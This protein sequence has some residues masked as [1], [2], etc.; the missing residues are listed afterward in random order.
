MRAFSL[1]F[2]INMYFV[3]GNC[4]PTS[5]QK[6]SVRDVQSQQGI[7]RNKSYSFELL[8][9]LELYS[10]ASMGTTSPDSYGLP[11]HTSPTLTPAHIKTPH[12]SCK[13][14]SAPTAVM[15]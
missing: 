12:V 1:L 2:Q 13:G 5:Q 9:L 3:S 8:L 7:F 15:L 6:L 14:P 11:H 4:W 10:G